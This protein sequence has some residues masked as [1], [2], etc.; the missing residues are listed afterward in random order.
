VLVVFIM[1]CAVLTF[2]TIVTL[3]ALFL[4]KIVRIHKGLGD[5]V[6]TTRTSSTHYSSPPT[7]TEQSVSAPEVAKKRQK[8]EAENRLL[9][10]RIVDLEARLTARP[11]I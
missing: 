10:E 1:A 2:S 9:R 11:D 6:S 5:K 4:N 7:G 8:L 3:I